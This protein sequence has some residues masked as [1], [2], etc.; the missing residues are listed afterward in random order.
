VTSPTSE[1]PPP[2]E[3]SVAPLPTAPAPAQP[4]IVE[5]KADPMMVQVVQGSG[6]PQRGEHFV[7]SDGDR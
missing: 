2:A 5:V 1:T 4:P 6:A 3:A 7:R